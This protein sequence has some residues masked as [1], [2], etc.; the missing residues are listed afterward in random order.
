MDEAENRKYIMITLYNVRVV[1]YC[2]LMCEELQSDFLSY[3]V[4]R[5]II[6]IRSGRRFVV[7]VLEEA[8]FNDESNLLLRFLH[9]K[10]LWYAIFK[11]NN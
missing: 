8:E 11:N 7:L 2:V 10:K 9:W 1:Q 4:C 6:S 3:L 5:E